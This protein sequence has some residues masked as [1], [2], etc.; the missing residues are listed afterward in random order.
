MALSALEEVASD[1]SDTVLCPSKLSR[2]NISIVL[3]EYRG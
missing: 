3:I 1:S 2:L